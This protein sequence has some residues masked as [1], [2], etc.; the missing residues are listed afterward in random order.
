MEFFLPHSLLSPPPCRRGEPAPGLSSSP[1]FLRAAHDDSL[2]RLQAL[3][4]LVPIYLQGL[5]TKLF[6]KALKTV[7]AWLM[8]IGVQTPSSTVSFISSRKYPQLKP[9]FIPSSRS[10]IK[11]FSQ[12]H[13]LFASSTERDQFHLCKK[14]AQ[15]RRE[16]GG[17]RRG[18]GGSSAPLQQWTPFP[19]LPC[20]IKAQKK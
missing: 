14:A 4:P 8:I 11:I 15:G 10:Q 19:L 7:G 9:P 12:T 16:K 20:C 13:S 2:S 6:I 17:E 5:N 3:C 1:H 18:W